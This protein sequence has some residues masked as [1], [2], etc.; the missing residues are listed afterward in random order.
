MT[1]T[2]RLF[3]AIWPAPEPATR[4][5]HE[6]QRVVEACGGRAIRAD[7][8]HLTLAFLGPLSAEQTERALI[9]GAAVAARRHETSL[10]FQKVEYWNGPRVAV[11]VSFEIPSLLSVLVEDLQ[12]SLRN[13]DFRL[14]ARAFRPHL[15]L[16]RGVPPAKA[17]HLPDQLGTPLELAINALCLVESVPHPDEG[18]RYTT[19]GQWPLGVECVG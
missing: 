15:T 14:E 11:A 9:I 8:L 7:K 1:T 5:A 2:S 13:E 3:F 17:A 19:R 16:A 6:A 18:V 4:L 12:G 10:L